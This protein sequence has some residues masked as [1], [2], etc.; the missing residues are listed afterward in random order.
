M[1]A[2]V[3]PVILK[4]LAD[5]SATTVERFAFTQEDLKQ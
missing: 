5:L 3:A 4:A 1:R 2:P